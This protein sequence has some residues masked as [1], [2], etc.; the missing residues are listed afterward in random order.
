MP[1]NNELQEIH[2]KQVIF[3]DRRTLDEVIQ[4]IIAK[5]D[6]IASAE[7]VAEVKEGEL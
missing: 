6:S 5:I 2:A 4:S 7:T 1:N 3:D